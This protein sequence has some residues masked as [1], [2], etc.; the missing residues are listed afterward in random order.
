M[1]FSK[2]CSFCNDTE[3][4]IFFLFPTPHNFLSTS[5][6]FRCHV[7]LNVLRDQFYCTICHT[8]VNMYF[9]VSL[10]SINSLSFAVFLAPALSSRHSVSIRQMRSY[11]NV[12]VALGTR[13]LPYIFS[14]KMS[15][16]RLAY[17]YSFFLIMLL[18]LIKQQYVKS[19][20]SSI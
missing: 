3:L 19:S 5:A 10:F 6:Q 4:W 11:S 16:T 1:A 15:H 2:S 13:N 17:T 9:S 20:F 18:T 7:L 8:R 12:G 14:H